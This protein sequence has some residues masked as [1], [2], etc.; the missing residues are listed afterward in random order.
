MK[1][2]KDFKIG[3]EVIC[4]SH[5]DNSDFYEQH[6]TIGKK[7]RI[8]DIEFRFPDKIC[9]ASDNGKVSMYFSV[10]MFSEN[11][12]LLREMKLKRILN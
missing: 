10:N 11:L 4:V 5:L 9:V 3:Q 12:N 2:Y 1:T 7:Y 6:L 8:V